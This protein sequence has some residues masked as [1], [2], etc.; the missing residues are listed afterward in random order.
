MRNEKDGVTCVFF[1]ETFPYFLS[2]ES[3]TGLISVFEG[4]YVR[5]TTK[6][7]FNFMVL[8][9]HLESIWVYFRK[10]YTSE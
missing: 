6:G 7:R 10:I 5:E 4:I 8:G 3:V 9:N 1:I 2:E